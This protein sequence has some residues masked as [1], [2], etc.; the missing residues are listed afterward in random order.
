[1]EPTIRIRHLN[2][3]SCNGCDIELLAA[4]RQDST[5]QLVTDIDKADVLLLTGAMTPGNAKRIDDA[6][7]TRGLPTVVLGACA[8]TQG[9]FAPATGALP[10]CLEP[11]CD[12]STVSVY[13]CPPPPASILG[14]LRALAPKEGDNH[15]NA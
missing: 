4:L 3:G 10:A 2:L 1:M 14:A 7:F 9:T 12:Q 8:A 15:G 5:L 11:G 6:V 13:G